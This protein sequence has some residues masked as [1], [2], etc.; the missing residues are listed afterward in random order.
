MNK[1]YD[2]GE[3][4]K[5]V[6]TIHMHFIVAPKYYGIYMKG[7]RMKSQVNDKEPIKFKREYTN[8]ARMNRDLKKYAYKLP[9]TTSELTFQEIIEL[10]FILDSMMNS[11]E[12]LL[13]LY[14]IKR[15]KKGG[16]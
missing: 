16:E 6:K 2:L 11:C 12:E 3:L 1:Y 8:I 15:T 13:R 14:K 10:G 5:L 9:L 4:N 7:F